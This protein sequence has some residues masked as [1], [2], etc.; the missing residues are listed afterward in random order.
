MNK[1]KAVRCKFCPF[2][3][4]VCHA[5]YFFQ[6]FHL[7]WGGDGV[8]LRLFYKHSIIFISIVHMRHT[9]IPIL[10]VCRMPAP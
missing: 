3:I 9:D 4:T 6:Y 2:V 1:L 7:G 8:G 5:I 10:P